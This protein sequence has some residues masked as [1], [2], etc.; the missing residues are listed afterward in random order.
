L[1][2][3][4]ATFFFNPVL[5]FVECGVGSSA[6]VDQTLMDLHTVWQ[7]L[8]FNVLICII[9]GFITHFMDSLHPIDL[10]NYNSLDKFWK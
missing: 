10:F 9:A 4:P 2:L 6:K 5:T 7:L 8:L 1:V 3:F